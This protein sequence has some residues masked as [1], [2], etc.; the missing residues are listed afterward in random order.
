MSTIGGAGTML[1][2]L[3]RRGETHTVDFNA[4]APRA[5]HESTYRVVGG[6]TEGALFPWPRVEDDANVF[7]PR[8]VA[9]PGSIPGLALADFYVSGH[10]GGQSLLAILTG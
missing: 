7:G 6:R 3:A 9:V 8:S 10:V 5:A 2:H 4:C 1:V